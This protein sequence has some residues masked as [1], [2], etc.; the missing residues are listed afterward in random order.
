MSRAQPA[1]SRVQPEPKLNETHLACA[2]IGKG[3]GDLGQLAKLASRPDAAQRWRRAKALVIDE[4]SPTTNSD[5]CC[6]QVT[7]V[8]NAVT[9]V[10][11]AVTVVTSVLRQSYLL[12]IYTGQ[13]QRGR[14]LLP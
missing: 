11:V 3:E 1:L 4:V 7:A 10:V 8:V 14:L 12:L 9:S 6:C 13:S 5:A 2:G